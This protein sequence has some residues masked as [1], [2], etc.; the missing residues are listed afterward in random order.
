MK[1][2]TS[3]LLLEQ[4]DIDTHTHTS[5]EETSIPSAMTCCRV[6]AALCL[7]NAG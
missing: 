2:I 5:G 1:H 3:R 6:T 4:S 7:P